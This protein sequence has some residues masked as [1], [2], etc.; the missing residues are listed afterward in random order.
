M[1]II[2]TEDKPNVY[3]FCSDRSSVNANLLTYLGITWRN[4]SGW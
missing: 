4:D 3:I 2:F 1:K